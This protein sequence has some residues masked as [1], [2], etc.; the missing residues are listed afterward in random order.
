MGIGRVRVLF[1]S[2]ITMVDT[3]INY[4]SID[5]RFIDTNIKECLK[6]SNKVIIPICDHLFDGTPEDMDFIKSLLQRFE[7]EPKVQIIQYEWDGREDA[8][9]HHNMSRWVGLQFCESDYV[10][11]L[12]ADEIIEGDLMTAYLKTDEYKTLDALSFRCYWY[13]REPIY[14]ALQTEMAGVMYKRSL[15]SLEMIFYKEERWAYRAV[16]GLDIREDITYN[17]KVMCHHYSWVRSKEEMMKKVKA[18]AHSTE[19]NWVQLV[20]N[21]FERPFNGTDFIHGYQF[22]IVESK[23]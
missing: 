15:C 17:N 22:E 20:E 7:N 12:D 8:K 13:F 3:I 21:E 18:W 2:V 11:F 10:L 19:K 6:F 14:R 9:Y 23:L 5:S 16:S 1:I 4:C